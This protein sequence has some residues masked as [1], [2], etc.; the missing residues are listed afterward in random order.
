MTRGARYAF[1]PFF[2]NEDGERLRQQNLRFVRGLDQ[3]AG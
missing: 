3:Q 1:L 2:F